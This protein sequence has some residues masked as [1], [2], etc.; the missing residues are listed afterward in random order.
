MIRRVQKGRHSRLYE[1]IQPRYDFSGIVEVPYSVVF[2]VTEQDYGNKV[3]YEV[4]IT[5]IDNLNKATRAMDARNLRGIK[6]YSQ[7]EAEEWIARNG[8]FI[9]DIQTLLHVVIAITPLL[10]F[11]FGK[12][13]FS[14]AYDKVRGYTV[15]RWAVY[16]AIFTQS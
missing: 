3:L 10:L 9:A 1:K 2:E 16:L 7:E 15:I 13:F 8:K 5:Y 6:F 11:E 14:R 4:T 12:E